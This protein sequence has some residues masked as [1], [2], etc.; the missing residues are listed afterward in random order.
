MP[1]KYVLSVTKSL[2]ITVGFVVVSTAA[3]A[4]P[5]GCDKEVLASMNKYAEAKVAYEVA[6][7]DQ[8]MKQPPSTL[9]MTCFNRSIKRMSKSS[10]QIAS[11]EPGDSSIS[12][13]Q[14]S[15]LESHYANYPKPTGGAS[16]DTNFNDDSTEDCKGIQ[17]EVTQEETRGVAKV[18]SFKDAMNGTD[19]GA[20]DSD[21][22]KSWSASKSRGSTSV[23]QDVKDL[24]TKLDTQRGTALSFDGTETPCKLLEKSGLTP[25]CE[26][27]E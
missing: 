6:V 9:A 10:N 14:K 24:N 1:F 20:S 8:V 18:P 26:T 25:S 17:N 23:V 13:A 27:G 15:A 4:L 11:G 19:E 16:Y 22:N 7:T 21:F 3:W 5:P 2:A 12:E